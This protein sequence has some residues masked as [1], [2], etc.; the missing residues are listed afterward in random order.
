LSKKI[1]IS[2]SRPGRNSSNVTKAESSEF[3]DL[4]NKET[5]NFKYGIG[6]ESQAVEKGTKS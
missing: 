3:T 5:M 6:K 4:S 2:A 1:K